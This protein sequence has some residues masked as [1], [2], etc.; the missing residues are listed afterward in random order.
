MPTFAR[1]ASGLTP[2]GQF[3]M[4]KWDG[5][6]ASRQRL[7]SRLAEVKTPNPVVLSGDVH[8]HYGADLKADYRNPRSAT[9]GVEFT[10]T[11]ITSNGDG[12]DTQAGWERLKA[13]NPHIRF[14]SARRGYIACTA[15]PADMRAEFRTIERVTVPD[16]PVPT[17]G[18]LVVEAGLPGSSTV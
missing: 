15:T 12:A 4:D 10:N 1:D 5:Y 17:S 3:S 2:D 14:H 13:D 8:L 9:V 18:A 11:S 7:Y 6:T 16:Q